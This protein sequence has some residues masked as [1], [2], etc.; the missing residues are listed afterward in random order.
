MY[1]DYGQVFWVK[2]DAI[3]EL[4]PR[5]CVL[6][7]QAIRCVLAGVE[8]RTQDMKQW[9]EAKLALTRLIQEQTLNM[10]VM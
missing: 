4:E 8:P 9:A 10:H 5:F 1:I 7:V 3:A 2:E 6:E